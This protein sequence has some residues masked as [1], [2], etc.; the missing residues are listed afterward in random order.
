M[1]VLGVTGGIGSGKST[2]AALLRERGARVLDAD[3]VV[4][5]MYGGGEIAQEI[6]ARFGADVLQADGSVDRAK[7]A[8]VVFADEAKLEE[9]EGLVHPAVRERIRDSID[10]WRREGF[11]GIVVVDAALLVETDHQYP[12]DALLVVTAPESLRI[13]RLRTRG[14]SA[15]EARRRMEHQAPDDEKRER[16]DFVIENE[17]TLTALSARV[18]ALLREL[19]RDDAGSSG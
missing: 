16:A 12:L 18:D 11:D 15:E 13:D 8:E 4:R 14:V 17:G 7:L 9:L 6:G 19:G 2:V 1:Y 5:T 10:E 3:R